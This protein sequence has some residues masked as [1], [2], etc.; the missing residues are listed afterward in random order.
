MNINIDNDC[1]SVRTWRAVKK[2]SHYRPRLALRIPGGWGSQIS[3][4]SAHESGK[5]VSHTHQPTLPPGNIPGT[6]FCYRLSR[7][8]GHSEARRIMSMK[9]NPMIP[10]GIEPATLWLVAQCLNQLLHRVPIHRVEFYIPI[11]QPTRCT[12]YRKLIILVKRSTCFGRPFRPSSGA[13][14]CVYSDGI[15]Q[16]AAATCCYRSSYSS[17][18]AA[19]VWHTPLLYTL[20]WA[21]DDGRKEGPKHVVRFTRINNL[22]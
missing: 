15:S 6:H 1:P 12:C 22:R 21:P 16:T 7:P 17:P 8:Q 5:V 2:Q 14:N 10:S 13:Q 18:I 3:R 19:A 11:V 9:K 20:F 4:Q